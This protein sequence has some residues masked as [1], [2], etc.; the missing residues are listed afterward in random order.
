MSVYAVGIA[1]ACICRS[2]L[3]GVEQTHAMSQPTLVPA[4]SLMQ[5]II[6]FLFCVM[7]LPRAEQRTGA[8]V[9]S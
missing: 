1:S 2:K 4:R 6:Q 9:Q 7:Y 5:P 3:V 8:S